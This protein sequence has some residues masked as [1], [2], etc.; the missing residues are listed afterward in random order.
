MK[1]QEASLQ[2]FL[3]AELNNPDGTSRRAHHVFKTM[4]GFDE[5][6]EEHL[7][8][9]LEQVIRED[10]RPVTV[11]RAGHESP[12]MGLK[13]FEQAQADVFFGRRRATN[14]VRLL[15]AARD[16]ACAPCRALGV[17][18]TDDQRTFV[19]VLGASGS[20]KS[21]LVRAGLLPDLKLPGMVERV[22]VC[23]EAVTRPGSGPSP[24]ESLVS[25]LLAALPEM[26]N[27]LGQSE[28][29]FRSE[30]TQTHFA[31]GI[32]LWV[33]N[34]LARVRAEAGLELVEH[35]VLRTMGE[36]RVLLIVDQL[37]ELFS[38]LMP[39]EQRRA[40]IEALDSL[41]ATGL[42]WVIATMRSDFMHQL[43]AEPLLA[44]LADQ[45]TGRYHLLPPTPTEYAEIVTR[46]VR[47]A[48]LEFQGA[49]SD[50][51]KRQQ[52][53]D[54]I[55]ADEAARHPGALP[56]LSFLLDQL[57][58]K[59]EGEV[60]TFEQY[61]ALGGL[62]GAVSTQ[63]DSVLSAQPAEVQGALPIVLRALVTAGVSE[64]EPITAVSQR[65]EYFG[66][67][68]PADRL[69]EAMVR[70][71]LFNADQDSSGRPTVRVTHEALLTHWNAAK[72]TLANMRKDLD[73]RRLL[74]QEAT[75]WRADTSE[76]RHTLLLPRG[77]RLEGAEDLLKRW[78]GDPQ[79]ES[80]REFVEASREQVRLEEQ[81]ERTRLQHEADRQ[82]KAA[83]RLRT[84]SFI[85][86][87]VG[88]VAVVA[89]IAAWNSRNRAV[90]SEDKAKLAA[91]AL[92]QAKAE[93]DQRNKELEAV[94]SDLSKRTKEL[95][96]A[97]EREQAARKASAESN[98][99]IRELAD[100]MIFEF[101]QPLSRIPG[102]SS[103]R[104]QLTNA[105]TAILAAR[106]MEAESDPSLVRSL[107]EAYQQRGLSESRLGNEMSALADLQKAVNYGRALAKDAAAD[108]REAS[109][110]AFTLRRLAMSLALFGRSIE[111]E[112]TFIESISLCEKGYAVANK[113]GWAVELSR[114]NISFATML[115]DKGRLPEALAQAAAAVRNARVAR[116]AF[117]NRL[118]KLHL[119]DALTTQVS[120]SSRNDWSQEWL[121]PLKESLALTEEVLA[122]DPLDEDAKLGVVTTAYQLGQKLVSEKHWS[123]ALVPLM[124]SRDIR[125][126]QYR[127][128]PANLILAGDVAHLQ[129]A[130][131]D[132]LAEVGKWQQEVNANAEALDLV[133]LVALQDPAVAKRHADLFRAYYRLGGSFMRI[134]I[135]ATDE[136]EVDKVACLTRAFRYYSAAKVVV[137]RV[138]ES[139]RSTV[140]DGS[141]IP[142]VASALED[143]DRRLRDVGVDPATI[144]L[145]SDFEVG[146]S[147]LAA[148]V[149]D[150]SPLQE[151]PDQPLRR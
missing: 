49:P 47:E 71:R 135:N 84:T 151:T 124:R 1:A 97:V 116:D 34:G 143:L 63:A 82:R 43:E 12:W 117:P 73:S 67:G 15:L 5:L 53:L 32:G 66:A 121:G 64:G 28:A 86:A 69:I 10:G 109:E 101:D 130:V 119:A 4:D 100:R 127:S 37:E 45:R 147:F 50:A 95:Q 150:V 107:F 98:K 102:T 54:R 52:S 77:L 65:R 6:L 33:R 18:P 51:R 9:S 31:K 126:S 141:L 136:Q 40:Y 23:R 108:S 125:R 133:R 42:V 13:A 137:A 56:L 129:W 72:S 70:A 113:P 17:T 90:E 103:V 26:N 131:A 29:A 106:E 148:P 104:G 93:T 30:L 27:Q 61:D 78:K 57:Y 134:A 94:N 25:A 138:P 3:S 92:T 7:A 48:G 99:R 76:R 85:L 41:A 122:E 146:P 24:F 128:D 74:S 68:T 123:E 60:L 145:L 20:G 132:A 87:V 14:E 112:R 80:T 11:A 96:E 89:G 58:Q 144:D 2:A 79:T 62:M 8:K 139:M 83:I 111:A 46:P 118:T 21:S 142:G 35:G 120:I 149:G 81:S 19:L 39:Q 44:R 110:L 115:K 75:E 88:T 114:G 36:A 22:A 38:S 91:E 55:I 105:A 59:R 140:L 16:K